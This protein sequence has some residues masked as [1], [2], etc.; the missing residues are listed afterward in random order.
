[1]QAEINGHGFSFFFF[2]LAP[3]I[4]IEQTACAT[5]IGKLTEI[6]QHGDNGMDYFGITAGEEN[7]VSFSGMDKEYKSQRSDNKWH[8]PVLKQKNDGLIRN[9]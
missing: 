2:F 3:V 7:G 6:K 8:S 4:I 1:M 5:S 9:R